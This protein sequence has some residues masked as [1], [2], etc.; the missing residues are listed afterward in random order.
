MAEFNIGDHVE[1]LSN[2]YSNKGICL[3]QR[4]KI[5]KVYP[6]TAPFWIPLYDV[7]ADIVNDPDEDVT[8][9]PFYENELRLVE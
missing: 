7:E 6:D 2:I 3:G 9:W 5:V 1:S 8:E 4:G